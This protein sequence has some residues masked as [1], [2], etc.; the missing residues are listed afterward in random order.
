MEK[1]DSQT[2]AYAPKKPFAMFDGTCPQC[3]NGNMFKYSSIKISKF[4]EMHTH[5]PNCNL[6]FEVEP[7]FWYGAM[8]MSYGFTIL[9]LIVMGFSLFYLFNDPS[10]MYYIVPITIISILVVPFNFRISRSVY[11]HLFGFIK[12]KPELN[13]KIK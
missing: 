2:A 3:R 7:G 8:F 11:L 4:D 6:R 10:V 5:C 9:L 1:K 13:K 12:Y